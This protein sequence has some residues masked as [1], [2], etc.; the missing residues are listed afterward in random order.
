MEARIAPVNSR[1]RRREES[2]IFRNTVKNSSPCLLRQKT[3]V[4]IKKRSGGSA[5]RRKSNGSIPD[6]GFLPKAATPRELFHLFDDEHFNWLAVRHQFEAELVKQGLF[7]RFVVC[8]LGFEK[9]M[10]LGY[11]NA[12]CLPIHDHT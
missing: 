12:V 9:R 10:P 6:G 4:G 8:V 1:G 2:Q 11:E 3:H 7:E 5:E